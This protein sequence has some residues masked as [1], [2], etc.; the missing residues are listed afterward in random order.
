MSK[1]MAWERKSKIRRGEPIECMGLVFYPIMMS[2]YEEFLEVRNALTVRLSTLPLEYATKSYLTALWEMDLNT[3]F[4]SGKTVG[5]FERTIRF[6][7]LSLRLDYKK[8]EA[9]NSVFWEKE[10]PR[11]LLYIEVTQDETVTK[12]TPQEFASRIRP[13]LAE[14]NGLE[15]PDESFNPDLVRS[16]Q[17]LREAKKAHVKV[18]PDTLIASVAYLCHL[19]E[20]EIDNWTV[21]QFERR[22][23]AIDRDKNFMLYRQAEMGGLVKFPK[24]NPFPSWCYDKEDGLSPALRPIGDVADKVKVIGDLQ[25][26]ILGANKSH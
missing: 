14:M 22:V 20:K 1:A 6:L 21:L 23:K 9:L 2:H 18:D 19:D 10:D 24:G 26:A 5:L 4:H 11:K 15:L 12:I 13:L 3:M 17:D 7:Y 8:E 25:T 16:E